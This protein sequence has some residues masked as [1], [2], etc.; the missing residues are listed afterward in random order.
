MSLPI[1]VLSLLEY[2]GC[3]MRPGTG[4]DRVLNL[5]DVDQP[6]GTVG[7]VITLDTL[8]HVEF[9]HRA[10]QEIH[11][12]LKP[13][14][15]AV[16]SSV[17]D[18][19]IHDSP[20]DYWRFTPDGFRSLLKPFAASFVGFAGVKRFPHT[21]TGIGFKSEAC[22]MDPFL[23]Q[24]EEWRH[25]WEKPKGESWKDTANLFVPPLL[26]RLDRRIAKL[27]RSQKT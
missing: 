4:V 1:F 20:T 26:Q 23:G 13:D 18:F 22:R 16:I 19:R 15:I 14:G 11:R 7:T 8:E 9:P 27:F 25:R 17:L 5:H 24:F 6:S 21:V 12:I 10:L 2:V 3:D